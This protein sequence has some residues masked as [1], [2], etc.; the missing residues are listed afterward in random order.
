MARAISKTGLLLACGIAIYVALFLVQTR[1]AGNLCNRY[2][3]GTRV[4]EIE[5]LE[6][7]VFLTKMG[8]FVDRDDPGAQ[9][10]IFCAALTM[11]DTSC[12]L[13]IKDGVVTSATL[14]GL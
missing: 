2:P 7:T 13:E 5:T 10:V 1:A 4:N 12:S 6:D 14:V 8:P 9:K 11:C 3:A